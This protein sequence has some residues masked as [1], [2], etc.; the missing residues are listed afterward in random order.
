MPYSLLLPTATKTGHLELPV[1]SSAWALSQP[2]RDR[3]SLI[4]SFVYSFIHSRQRVIALQSWPGTQ[5][6][7]GISCLHLP[8][9]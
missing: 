8:G 4:C 3:T 9:L 2:L 5:L 6:K 1:A 7:G